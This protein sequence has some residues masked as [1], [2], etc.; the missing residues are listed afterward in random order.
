MAG[1]V[2]DQGIT[3][4]RLC[5]VADLAEQDGLPALDEALHSHLLQES[6]REGGRM[7]DGRYVFAHA[8]V[9]A[10]VYA[11]AGE[12]RRSIFHRRAVNVLQEAAAPPAVLAYHALAAGLAEPAFRF[13]LAAGDEAMRVV[14]VRDAITFYEQARHLMTKQVHGLG[15]LTLLPAPE[16][17]HLYTEL[18][19]AYELNTEWAKARAVYTAMLAYARDACQS[20]MESTAQNH[21][22]NLTVQ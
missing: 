22:A 18:G 2:L 5:Q 4:E 21:L 19:R 20:A 16:I 12:A 13:S 15:L 8:K 14:A 10:V 6:E 3:F 11:E 17:E 7:A 1:A 9:R